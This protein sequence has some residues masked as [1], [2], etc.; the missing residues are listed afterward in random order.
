L[1]DPRAVRAPSCWGS[2]DRAEWQ[3]RC[4]GTQRRGWDGGGGGGGWAT[5]PPLLVDDEGEEDVEGVEAHGESEGGDEGMA[6]GN[7]GAGQA[8]AARKG[9][10]AND[11]AVARDGGGAG[12]DCAQETGLAH[13]APALAP[14]P[15]V[16]D[17]ARVA[18]CG[19]G[20]DE[21]SSGAGTV[22]EEGG[23]SG[24]FGG[25]GHLKRYAALAAKAVDRLADGYAPPACHAPLQAGGNT[26]AAF[27]AGA[28]SVAARCAA[29]AAAARRPFKPP[30]RSEAGGR[31]GEA[32][33]TAG[34]G[35]EAF[36]AF[37][38]G[39][40]DRGPQQLRRRMR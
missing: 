27:A 22:D 36:A 23:G 13:A 26:F 8:A 30:Q 25:I 33:A 37:A 5:G 31:Q 18:D 17:A 3:Q 39:R 4:S 28:G 2:G 40:E 16:L 38:C 6:G 12:A 32:P 34:T 15:D 19:A 20:G 10:E 29:G 9:A 7:S 21:N 11:G 1:P 14:L 35:G 24:G